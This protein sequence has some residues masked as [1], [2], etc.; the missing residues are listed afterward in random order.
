MRFII[1]Q[2]CFILSILASPSPD[3][4]PQRFDMTRYTDG[5]LPARIPPQTV[6]SY[7]RR[8][9]SPLALDHPTAPI[10]DY[11]A[12]EDDRE[13]W[14]EDDEA[15]DEEEVEEERKAWQL[16]TELAI[17]KRVWSNRARRDQFVDAAKGIVAQRAGG[18][19]GSGRS[20]RGGELGLENRLR[21]DT[22]RFAD[23]LRGT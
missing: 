3:T 5:M 4:Q 8:T 12:D 10:T 21:E 17:L 18:E 19:S 23:D 6:Q 2:F 9:T 7:L 1:L 22:S 15:E 11:Q 14:G 16:S 13:G 20:Y